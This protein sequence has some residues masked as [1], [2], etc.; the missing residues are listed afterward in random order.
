MLTPPK[1]LE[2]RKSDP[3]VT[4]VRN[5]TLPHW[6]RW[7]GV[8]NRCVVPFNSVTEPDN[9]TFGGRAPVWFT[10]GECRPTACFAGL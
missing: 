9:G 4:N 6:R 8:E 3:G 1:F 7:Q 5:V 2:G 10:F